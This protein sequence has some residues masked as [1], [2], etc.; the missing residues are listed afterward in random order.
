M[1][2]QESS[3]VLVFRIIK[4]MFKTQ[5]VFLYVQQSK[6]KLLFTPL[7]SSGTWIK[8][9]NITN[10]FMSR[11]VRMAKNYCVDLFMF[12]CQKCTFFSRFSFA[13][14]VDYANRN[15]VKRKK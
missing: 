3:L 14:T 4:N 6:R 7:V 1:L 13:M 15:V 10:L 2:K 8:Q 5:R 11:N 9:R 12:K